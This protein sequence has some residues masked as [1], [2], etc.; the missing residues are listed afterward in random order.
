MHSKK[1]VNILIILFIFECKT[2]VILVCGR[3]EDDVAYYVN[4]INKT[5]PFR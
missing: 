4:P 1:D 2:P 5:K 3:G